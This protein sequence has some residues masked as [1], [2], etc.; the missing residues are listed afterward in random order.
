[1]SRLLRNHLEQA[2]SSFSKLV[3]DSARKPFKVSI[4][5]KRLIGPRTIGGSA[6]RRD[7]IRNAP[8]FKNLII[9]CE[10]CLK[11]NRF[12]CLKA[13]QPTPNAEN[14]SPHLVCPRI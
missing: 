13:D 8:V 14:V 1:R 7:L 6:G 9:R 11:G 4:P 10:Q 12:C 5:Q 2:I 3:E